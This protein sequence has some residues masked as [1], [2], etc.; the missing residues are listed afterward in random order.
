MTVDNI[1]KEVNNLSSK[2]EIQQY[3]NYKYAR[4]YAEM[5]NRDMGTGKT[6]AASW[7][8]EQFG[9]REALEFSRHN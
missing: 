6:I 8:N 3:S 7:G 1:E 9:A 4:Q 5:Q 2:E